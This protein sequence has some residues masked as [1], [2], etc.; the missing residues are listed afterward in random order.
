MPPDNPLARMWANKLTAASAPPI[1]D[2]PPP[3]SPTG[4]DYER[5]RDARVAR[6]RAIM[7]ELGINNLAASIT[8]PSRAEPKRKRRT[9]DASNTAVRRGSAPTSAP[10]RRST[11]STRHTGPFVDEVNA[12]AL[13]ASG[14]QPRG[15]QV[16][17]HPRTAVPSHTTTNGNHEDDEEDPEEKE[18]F[19][20]SGV[21]R[22]TAWT[23]TEEGPFSVSLFLFQVYFYYRTGNCTDA[24]FYFQSHR[25]QIS[26]TDRR[27]D[28]AE[29]DAD[30]DKKRS[31]KRPPLL[32]F[33]ER[34]VRF[35]DG[36]CKKGFYSIDTTRHGKY[37]VQTKKI[38]D[39]SPGAGAMTP[40][41][42]PALLAAG[43]DGGRCAVFALGTRGRRFESHGGRTTNHPHRPMA[44]SGTD[45]V[46][47]ECDKDDDW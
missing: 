33:A 42:R 3:P 2:P 24:V 28:D 16:G 9:T 46:E 47:V 43:G 29:N 45:K 20:D 19:D 6:N 14:L 34:P 36:T 31:K 18:T 26:A 38:G 13:R 40:S 12:D 27:D 10:T 41:P 11:R 23:S 35:I 30:A 37:S 21:L 1:D 32:G 7:Q 8:V 15:A 25:A 4:A 39:E 22:Y 17:A 5:E 44:P